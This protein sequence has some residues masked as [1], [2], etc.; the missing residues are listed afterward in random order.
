[1]RTQLERDPPP[2]VLAAMQ[3]DPRL[4]GL[5]LATVQRVHSSLFLVSQGLASLLGPGGPPKALMTA[6]GYLEEIG[7]AIIEHATRQGGR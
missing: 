2:P 7:E 6:E 5:P 3:M 4:G 1:M